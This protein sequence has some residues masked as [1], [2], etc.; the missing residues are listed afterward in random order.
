MIDVDSFHEIATSL[1]RH[2]LRTALTALGVFFGLTIF[3]LMV[4][5]GGSL[6]SGI[7][8]KMSGFAT[9]AVFLWGQRTSEPYAGLPANRPVVFDNDDI[10]PLRKLAGVEHV[11]P[12]NQLGG[13]RAGNVVKH[14]SKVG[15]FQV[16]GDYPDFQFISMPLIRAGR[17]IN[18]A[19]IADRRK[20]AVIGESVASE[21]FGGAD[22]IGQALEVNGIHF[23]VVGVF[24]TRATGQQGDQQVRTIHVPFTTFQQAFHTGN[25]VSWFAL[26]GKRGVDAKEL[27]QRVYALLRERHKV[28]PTD[29]A[30]IRGFNAGAQFAKTEKMFGAIDIVLGVFGLLSLL[31]GA[32]GVSNIMLISV[33]E[34]TKEIGV[35]KALGA[36]PAAVVGMVI[37][38]AVMLTLVAGFIALAVGAFAIS[39]AADR[40]AT[41]G[42]DF[43][44][45]PPQVSFSFSVLATV[46]LIAVGA[47][48]GLIP[49]VRAAAI[50]PVEALRDE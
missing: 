15:A 14:G 3:M 24:G 30:A 44:L 4:S 31:A 7:S 11:A 12:R 39:K 36:R 18:D 42:P 13:F 47:L 38:E 8:K 10:E 37:A 22:P 5:F 19:D 50:S 25:R 6:R 40:I 41:M 1:T 49:A 2:K 45:G 26:T 27:E 23:V 20:V 35:R 21:L 48:A 16:A 33:R 34:R 17:Y 32:I 28:A 9:N 43:P 46:I 29:D